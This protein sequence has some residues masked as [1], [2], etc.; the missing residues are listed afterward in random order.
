MTNT[1]NIERKESFDSIPEVDFIAL[2]D[3]LEA[4]ELVSKDDIPMTDAKLFELSE[5]FKPEP[6]LVEDKQRF[7]LFPIKYN[8]VREIST[9]IITPH[10]IL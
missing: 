8:D 3:N 2:A 10:T 7:V 6:L 5:D 1:T 9:Y 4:V